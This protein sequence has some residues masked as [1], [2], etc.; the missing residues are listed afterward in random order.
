MCP[1][2]VQRC[3]EAPVVVTVPCGRNRCGG[4]RAVKKCAPGSTVPTEHARPSRSH[5]VVLRVPHLRQTKRA[6]AGSSSTPCL[7]VVHRGD[8]A[9]GAGSR[10][11]RCSP[12]CSSRRLVRRLPQPRCVPLRIPPRRPSAQS[13]LDMPAV[14]GPPACPGCGMP[15]GIYEPLW[16]VSPSIGAELTSWLRL[17]DWHPRESLW[18]VECAETEG[19]GGG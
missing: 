9:L 17:R 19:I 5:R 7:D 1:R 4:G 18:H 2:G 3:P 12:R 13:W 11:V 6:T 15:I 10:G 8:P 14:P 16:R